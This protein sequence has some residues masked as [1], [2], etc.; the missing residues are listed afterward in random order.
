M[1]GAAR[2]VGDR[3]SSFAMRRLAASDN[4]AESGSIFSDS[5]VVADVASVFWLRPF[6]LE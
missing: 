5:A 6:D 4:A 1:N 3:H 2:V